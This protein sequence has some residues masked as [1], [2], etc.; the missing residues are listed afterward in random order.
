MN[1]VRA[2]SIRSRYA[3]DPMPK[4]PTSATLIGMSLTRAVR[5]VGIIVVKPDARRIVRVKSGKRMVRRV[6]F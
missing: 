6:K 3:H 1:G 4:A 2:M 5:P